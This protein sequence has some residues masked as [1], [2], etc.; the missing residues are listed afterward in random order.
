[1]EWVETSV[2]CVLWQKDIINRENE[3]C[4]DVWFQDSGPNKKTGGRGGGGRAENV[5]VFTGSDQNDVSVSV[6]SSCLISK[7]KIVI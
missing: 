2:R 1:M 3:N 7:D 6:G 4:Y 5:K